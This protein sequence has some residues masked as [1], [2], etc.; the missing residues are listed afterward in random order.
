MISDIIIG[1]NLKEIRNANGFTQEAVADF[2][3]VKER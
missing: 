2:I 1:K 3:G